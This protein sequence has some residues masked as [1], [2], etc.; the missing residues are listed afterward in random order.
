MHNDQT[1]KTNN[2]QQVISP[3][4]SSAK[5]IVLQWLT[6]S[7]WFWLLLIIGILL[8]SSLSYFLG[9]KKGD[10]AWSIYMLAPLLVLLPTATITDRFYKRSE[11][12]EKHGFSAVVMIVS[13]VVSCL[14]TVSSFIAVLI[15]VISLL[16]D[17][18]N[19]DDKTVVIISSFVAGV[20]SLLLF[21]RILYLE[22][23][24]WVRSK[25]STIVIVIFAITLGLTIIG[26]LKSEI[27]RKS[28]R[29]VEKRYSNIVRAINDYTRSEKQ[30]PNSLSDVDFDSEDKKAISAGSITYQKL[31]TSNDDYDYYSETNGLDYEKEN[32][33]SSNKAY[34][35]CVI[36]KY[37]KSSNYETTVGE[38][39][40][41]YSYS[42]HKKGLQCY[43]E[44]SYSYSY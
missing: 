18:G 8:S 21:G 30:L 34:K 24:S 14:I 16:I 40:S 28:D 12:V 4:K 38:N 10:Y 2:K 11:A 23:L 39:E 22:N 15:S 6:Y 9:D 5:E 44:K 1:L 31:D 43:T 7:F 42:S 33:S 3:K 36:W 25:F 29:L 41:Y 26:P 13:A 32:N 17:S 27:S 19:T 35:L 37:E 20:L